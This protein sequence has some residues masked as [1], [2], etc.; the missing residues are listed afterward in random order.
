[1]SGDVRGCPGMSGDVRVTMGDYV[2]A[3]AKGITV[4]DY[5]IAEA[6]GIQ[7][8]HEAMRKDYQTPLRLDK[9]GPLC[10]TGLGP[11]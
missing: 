9:Y 10:L 3:E 7:Q 6:Q 1:M 4:G 11:F 8:T 5:V 2:I